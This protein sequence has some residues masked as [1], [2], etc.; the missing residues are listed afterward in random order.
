M[1]EYLSI[2]QLQEQM[3]DLTKQFGQLT[4]VCQ[5]LATLQHQ[6]FECS[7]NAK[8]ENTWTQAFTASIRAGYSS[9]DAKRI[10]DSA[11]DNFKRKFDE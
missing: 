5:S 1:N 3:A 9:Y 11:V 6:A 4:D 7:K 8:Y 10:A 2:K